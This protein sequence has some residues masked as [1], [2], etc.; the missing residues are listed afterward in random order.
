MIDVYPKVTNCSFK[1]PVIMVGPVV[2]RCVMTA[3]PFFNHSWCVDQVSF[4][5]HQ[6]VQ[7]DLNFQAEIKLLIYFAACEC[8]L[9]WQLPLI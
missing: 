3:G 9:T 2:T 1:L 8:L 5:R 4:N 6:I 7:S